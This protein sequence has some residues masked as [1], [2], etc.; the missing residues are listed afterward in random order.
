M[1]SVF[2]MSARLP[3]QS[4]YVKLYR[5]EKDNIATANRVLSEIDR[6]KSVMA[7]SMYLTPLYDVDELYHSSHVLDDEGYIK[8]FTDV[9][10]LDLRPYVYDSSQ[11]DKYARA[12]LFNGYEIT[13]KIE[14]IIMVLERQP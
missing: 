13:T 3:S 2:L 10:V 6:D 5:E 14:D 11:A 4:Y 1:A 12:Y 8:I 9:V 7:T